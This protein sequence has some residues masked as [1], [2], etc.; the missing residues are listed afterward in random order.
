M[1]TLTRVGRRFGHVLPM[2]AAGALLAAPAGHTRLDGT[3]STP[4]PTE[5]PVVVV[6][7]SE[8]FDWGD[9]GLGAGTAVAI[10][11]FGGAAAAVVTRRRRIPAHEGRRTA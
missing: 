4:T 8:G 1:R 5:R 7:P 6:D 11:L 2:V 9:A 3:P 10:A